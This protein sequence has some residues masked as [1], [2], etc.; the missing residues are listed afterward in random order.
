MSL[1]LK[2]QNQAKINYSQISYLQGH[3]QGFN[4]L[5]MGH[6]Y[7]SQVVESVHAEPKDTQ[8]PHYEP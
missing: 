1:L 7:I 5:R 4:E 2:T 8:K 3:I 6:V